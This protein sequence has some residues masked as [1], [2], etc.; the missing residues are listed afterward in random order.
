MDK[1]ICAAGRGGGAEVMAMS[2]AGMRSE[3]TIRVAMRNG[4]SYLASSYFTPPFKVANITEDRSVNDLHLMLMCSSPG[5]LDGDDLSLKVELEADS[6]LQLH[7]QSYQR[8]FRMREGACQSMEVRL[9]RGAGF[10]WLPH[11][12]VPHEQAIFMGRNKVF[13]SEGCQL[14]WGEVLTCGRKLNGEIFGFSKYHVRTEIFIHE[15]LAVL[16]NVCLRP[17][18]LS[19]GALGQMEG[20]THQGSLLCMGD[21]FGMR[22]RE[23]ENYLSGVEGIIYGVSEGPAGGL[24][25][26]ILGNKAEP[27]YEALKRM[28]EL[29]SCSKAVAYAS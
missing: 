25:V 8:L 3:V 19:M 7:T 17:S 27:L 23:I 29:L 2:K 10:C 24:V 18:V 5:V 22:R 20:F 1:E 21:G 26:R 6:R 12:C 14:L 11:P 28:A 13:L 9:G 15:Q 16:E 4:I